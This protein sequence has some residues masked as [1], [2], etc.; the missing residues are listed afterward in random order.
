M[1]KTCLLVCCLALNANAVDE[2]SSLSEHNSEKVS[3]PVRSTKEVV[4]PSSF[5]DPPCP[6]KR[7]SIFAEDP[8]IAARRLIRPHRPAF[9]GYTKKAIQELLQ[10][11]ENKR[12]ERII[13]PSPLAPSLSPETDA[14]T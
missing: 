10:K 13:A 6:E 4:P 2:S 8:A 7:E 11:E 5:F 14:N 3:H 1:K 9:G 12:S